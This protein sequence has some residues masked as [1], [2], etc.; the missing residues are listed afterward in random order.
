MAEALYVGIEIGGTKSVATIARGDAILESCRVPTTTP[1]ATLTA[2]RDAALGWQRSLGP[3][4]ALGIGSFGPLGVDPARD[5][6][7]RIGATPKPGWSGANVRGA[8]SGAVAGPV[9]I[10]TDVAAA[11]LA[12]GRWGASAGCAVHVYLTVGTGVGAGVVVDG[13]PV[14]GLMHPE[15][16]HVRVRRVPGDAFAGAC[17]FHGDCLEGLV[18]GA[19]IASRAGRSGDLLPSS[20]PLWGTVAAALGEGVAML[21]L[22]LAAQRVVIGGGVMT[23]QSQLLPM[24]RAHAAAALAGYVP[25]AIMAALVVAPG[26]GVDSGPMGAIALAQDAAMVAGQRGVGAR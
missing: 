13:R 21:V 15:F 16:G 5:D 20:D 24:I 6:Y 3:A 9:A 22:T 10:D 23:G 25:A 11:A 17:P 18:S 8:L 26:L 4:A 2:C 19:A 7:G 12:E 1:A 14:H